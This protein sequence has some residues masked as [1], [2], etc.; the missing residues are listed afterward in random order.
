MAFAI[1]K[2]D[3]AS[4]HASKKDQASS[5]LKAEQVK[6][7]VVPGSPAIKVE[8]IPSSNGKNPFLLVISMFIEGLFSGL[9][10]GVSEESTDLWPVFA[11]IA[12]HKWAE[13]LAI[14]ISFVKKDFSKT[15]QTITAI[16][17][18]LDVPI[19][20][21]IGII[22]HNLNSKVR[23]ILNAITAGVFIYQGA[24]EIIG[25]EFSHAKN[26]GIKYLS[27]AVGFGFMIFVFFLEKWFRD[28][29][30]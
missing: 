8:K 4:K 7:M 2:D 19:G 25:E 13:A 15:K 27:Y 26:K 1:K 12:L 9:A 22:A 30:G 10:L 23:G 21:A 11:A 5:I 28:H 29:S 16:L 14:G 17:I 20:G 6:E 24:T 3:E 18:A